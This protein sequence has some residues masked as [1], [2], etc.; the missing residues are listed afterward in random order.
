MGR[1]VKVASSVQELATPL[2]EEL[3]FP[4]QSAFILQLEARFRAEVA[5]LPEPSRL[6]LYEILSK[7]VPS[8]TSTTFATAG[9]MV[10]ALQEGREIAFPS[11]LPLIKLSHIACGYEEWLQR[12]Y[13]L[14][15]FV[16]VQAGDVVVDCGA[17]VGGFSMSALKVAAYVHAFEPEEANFSCLSRNLSGSG[18]IALNQTGLYSATSRMNLNISASSVEHSLLLPDD[19]QAIG[20]REI[21]VLAL[22]DYCSTR[23]ICK[24]DFLKIEAEGV[25]PEVFEGLGDLKPNKLAI[26]V[27]PERNSESPAEELRA[28]LTPLGYEIRQRAHVM[29]ARMRS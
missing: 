26:D 10:V 5:K 29:F 25:E 18:N 13:S 17:Y 15:G 1:I 16:E 12:K 9:N 28:R 7:L 24:L 23:N 19:G 4:N 22:S 27:S 8:F 21:D 11:P 3:F 20:V 6:I 2:E 14:P